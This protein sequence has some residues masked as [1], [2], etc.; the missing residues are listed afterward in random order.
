MRPEWEGAC[1]IARLNWFEVFIGCAEVLERISEI[2]CDDPRN[3]TA[4][5]LHVSR[6]DSFFCGKSRVE[7]LLRGADQYSADDFMVN[8][9]DDISVTKDAIRETFKGTATPT[10]SWH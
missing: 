6:N 3:I 8:N 10:P 9:D 2:Y 1:P 4:Q 5:H 7:D